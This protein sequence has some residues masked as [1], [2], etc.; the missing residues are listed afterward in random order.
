MIIKCWNLVLNAWGLK[1]FMVVVDIT[2]KLIGWT[3]LGQKKERYNE[4]QI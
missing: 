3:Q 4:I 2:K 1:R